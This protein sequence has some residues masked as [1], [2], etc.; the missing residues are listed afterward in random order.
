MNNN[1]N[2]IDYY[3]KIIF[4]LKKNKSRDQ[5]YFDNLD[6]LIKVVLSKNDFTELEKVA[7]LRD[8]VYSNGSLS[9]EQLKNIDKELG[10]E[11]YYEESCR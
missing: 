2:F 7:R 3:N 8:L 1:I 6:M 10:Y 4:E 5:N 9:K 11:K